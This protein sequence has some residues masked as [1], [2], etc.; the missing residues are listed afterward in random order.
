[1]T[2]TCILVFF[3]RSNRQEQRTIFTQSTVSGFP[4]PSEHIHPL[5]FISSRVTRWAWVSL[6]GHF[7][8]TGHLAFRFGGETVTLWWQE[9]LQIIFRCRRGQPCCRCRCRWRPALLCSHRSRSRWGQSGCWW[10]YHP[11]NCLPGP[12]EW[13]YRGLWA[14]PCQRSHP[15]ESHQNVSFTSHYCRIYNKVV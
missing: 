4:P 10:L 11:G 9:C 1:M 14:S 8:S 2:K 12:G 5:L 6:W 3:T 15:K 13:S 7:S